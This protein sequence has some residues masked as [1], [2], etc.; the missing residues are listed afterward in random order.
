MLVVKYKTALCPVFAN[1]Y[2]EH[3]THYTP[4][5]V[6]GV[7]AF[8]QG[9]CFVLWVWDWRVQTLPVFVIDLLYQVSVEYVSVLVT[10]QMKR[11]R[12]MEFVMLNI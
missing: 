7:S 9:F 2:N 11:L 5:G 3:N 4:K 10:K 6:L 1:L 12:V 8:V